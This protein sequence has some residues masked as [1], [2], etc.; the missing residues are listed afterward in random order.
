ML[1]VGTEFDV[2]TFGFLIF[3]MM[4]TI[5]LILLADGL[6]CDRMCNLLGRIIGCVK[7][8]QELDQDDIAVVFNARG[9][10]NNGQSTSVLLTS[11]PAETQQASED[12]AIEF[13]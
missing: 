7:R 6:T 9:G 13:V 2:W 10:P 1:N 3:A 8:Y 12:S 11:I 4:L 5:L